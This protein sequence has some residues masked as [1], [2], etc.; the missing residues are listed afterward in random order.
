M[1][2]PL[3]IVLTCIEY[4]TSSTEEIFAIYISITY[5]ILR[6]N[7]YNSCKFFSFLHNCKFCFCMAVFFFIIFGSIEALVTK[8]RSYTMT[9]IL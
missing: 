4:S 3:E 8:T 1:F 9:L 2:H 7:K 5:T 6:T